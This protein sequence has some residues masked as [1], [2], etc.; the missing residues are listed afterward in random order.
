MWACKNCNE[1][2]EDKFDACW[3][4]GTSKDGIVDDSFQNAD[5]PQFDYT[6][7]EEPGDNSRLVRDSIL[8][9][10][11]VA[12]RGSRV[13]NNLIDGMFLQFVVTPAVGSSVAVVMILLS[14]LGMELVDLPESFFWVVGCGAWVGYFVVTESI[15]Q[16]TLGKLITGTVV[17]TADGYKPSFKQIVGR[18]IARLIPF[19]PLSFLGRYPVGWH[20]SLSRTRV[21][22]AANLPYSATRVVPREVASSPVA[23]P[24]TAGSWRIARVV[25]IAVLLT[26]LVV[27]II[28]GIDLFW[29]SARRPNQSSAAQPTKMAQSRPRRTNPRVA[30]QRPQRAE[31]RPSD[32]SEELATLRIP[33]RSAQA[34]ANLIDL[35]D[36]YNAR[37]EGNW[38]GSVS[39]N[40]LSE[41]PQGI[42]AF[43]G[44]EFDIRGIVQIAGGKYE[45]DRF[46]R[47]VEGIAVP[48]CIERIHFL[49]GTLWGHEEVFGT[50]IGKYVLRYSDGSS[51]ERQ[52]ILGEDVLD[53]FAVPPASETGG[54]VVAWSGANNLSRRKGMTIQ[55]YKT[56]WENPRP[57]ANILGLDFIS[58]D[59]TAAPFLVA[60]TVE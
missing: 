38:H 20:D 42:Q 19:E 28:L 9:Q 46:P 57:D 6:S 11:Q 2:C 32:W 23:S 5:D 51:E 37:F 14:V 36:F 53:W 45:V 39:D 58:A 27:G 56:T 55:L 31:L 54:P 47:R 43:G 30:V 48:G 22:H 60:I 8:T 4:C 34:S 29:I 44:T 50:S 40:D 59:Q 41:L 7:W 18:S 21:V 25:L 52:L 12:S 35:T 24:G 1:S 26:P 3:R 13:C 10:R 15:W 49:H 33:P 16:K 17:V